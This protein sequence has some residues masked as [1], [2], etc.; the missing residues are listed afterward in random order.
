MTSIKYQKDEH[1]IVHLILDKAQA[2]ANLMDAEFCEDL[3]SC[4]TQL[5]QDQIQGVIIRS[6]KSTFFAGGDIDLLYQTNSENATELFEMVE[7]I[8]RSFRRIETM[9]KPVVA[10]VAGAALGGG[11]EVVLCAHYRI[12]LNSKS[13][14]F[15]FPE[16]TL[17]LL[18]G[19]GGITRTTRMLGLKAAMPILLEGKNIRAQK[20]LELGLIDAVAEDEPTMLGQAIDWINNHTKV[21]KPWDEKGFRIPGGSLNSPSVAQMLSIAPAILKQKTA[22]LLPAPEK[23]L[24]T[25]VEGMQVDF[26]TASQIES[27]YFVELA[28]SPVSKNLIK[29]FWYQ[30]NQIKAGVGRPKDYSTKPIKKVGILGAGMM[31]AGIA[32]ACANKGISVILKDVSLDAAEKGKQYSEKLLSKKVLASR[33]SAQKKSEILSLIQPT[34]SAKDLKGCELVIEAVFENRDLKAQVTKE[35][36]EYLSDGVTFASN[37]STLPISGL[38]EA[39]KKPENFIGLHFFSPVDKM[40][41]VEIIK[42]GKTSESTLANS[43][44]FVLQIAKTPIV[45]ND[46]RGFFTSRGFATF[47]KEGI[48]MLGEGIAAESIEN[49]ASL[50][51]FPVGPLAVTDEVSLTLID[52]IRKQTEKDCQSEGIPIPTHPADK[53]IEQMMQFNRQGKL[54]GAGFYEYPEGESKYLWSGLKQHFYQAENQ[55]ELTAIKERLLYIMALESTRCMQESVIES[56]RDANIGSIF[57]IGYPA[58]TGGVLQYINYQGLDQFIKR[59]TQF[60]EIYGSRFEPSEILFNKAKD[61]ELF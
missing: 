2:K 3:A 38:A 12:A 57:G 51:G 24:A 31:G 23:I 47:V 22:G 49:A 45:V 9:N 16:V 35:A 17:G 4:I 30:L 8:K 28:C 41:L 61:K 42:G 32:Y 20:A 50:A 7:S 10:C 54:S 37:T 48:A 40:P 19:A 33:L 6:A 36:E 27:R 15:G 60:S 55:I 59:T 29:A 46:S 34:G 43:Y 14:V 1:N 53:V 25:M 21:R 26:D 11:F 44:D 5:E 58:W 52:K 39:A 56:S 18:P 13:V